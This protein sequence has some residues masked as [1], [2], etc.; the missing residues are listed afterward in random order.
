RRVFS[1][2]AD[3]AIKALFQALDVCRRY[4][5]RGAGDTELI[6]DLLI[7]KSRLPHSLPLCGGPI[8]DLAI[9][10][11]GLSQHLDSGRHHGHH[12]G[13]TRTLMSGR[14][15]FMRPRYSDGVSPLRRRGRGWSA[16]V[17]PE[18]LVDRS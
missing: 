6:V 15:A 9:R 11:A 3:D 4:F 13:G 18:A 7:G 5:F 10:K 2:G 12:E 17:G 1:S 14:A 8:A 16:A